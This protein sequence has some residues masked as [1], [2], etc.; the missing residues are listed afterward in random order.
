MRVS[1][2]ILV[3]LSWAEYSLDTF[4]YGNVLSLHASRNHD[5]RRL[6]RRRRASPPGDIE[7]SRAAGAPRWRYR[8]VSGFGAAL[9]LEASPRPERCGPRQRAPRWPPYAV[10]N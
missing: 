9:G 1:A 10:Q 8:S 5:L 2:T 4:P 7:L 6:Q 3:N